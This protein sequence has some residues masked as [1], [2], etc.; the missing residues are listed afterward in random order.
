MYI[1]ETLCR[2][3]AHS[4]APALPS[5]APLQASRSHSAGASPSP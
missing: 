5:T 4:G 3:G 1:N 2:R